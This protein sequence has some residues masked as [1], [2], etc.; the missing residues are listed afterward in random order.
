MYLKDCL[1]LVMTIELLQKWGYPAPTDLDY[2]VKNLDYSRMGKKNVAA[3][4]S[5][6]IFKYLIIS[7]LWKIRGILLN[8]CENA[9]EK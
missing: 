8:F 7:R 9:W 2:S 6:D 1:N 4:N 5:R 3:K